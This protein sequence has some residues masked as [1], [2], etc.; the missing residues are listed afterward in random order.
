MGVFVVLVHTSTTDKQQYAALCRAMLKHQD[1]RFPG[2]D[3]GD[4]LKIDFDKDPDAKRNRAYARE[5]R[6]REKRK[7]A[8]ESLHSTLAPHQRVFLQPCCKCKD[9]VHLEADCPTEV[10]ERGSREPQRSASVGRVGVGG[11][12]RTARWSMLSTRGSGQRSGLVLLMLSRP[13]LERCFI[14]SGW[15]DLFNLCVI[16]APA[17]HRL[18]ACE[19]PFATLG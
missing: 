4:G 18:P 19:S 5:E 17:Y 9:T 1:H 2:I 11:A 13:K 16:S 15:F 3:R 10:R 8:M 6:L 14:Y 12:S 7:A